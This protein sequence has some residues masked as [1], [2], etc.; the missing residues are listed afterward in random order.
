M[1]WA[2]II[3]ALISAAATLGGVWLS[4]IFKAKKHGSN[5][6]PKHI[7]RDTVIYEVISSLRE[8][9]HFSRV[10]V[11]LFHNG[12]KYYHGEPMQK[13]SVA[14]ETLFPGVEPL[15]KSMQDVPVSTMTYSLKILSE[16]G[17]FIVHDVS[18]LDNPNYRNLMLSYNETQHYAFKVEDENGW[19]GV[20]VCDYTNNEHAPLN[21]Q[22]AEYIKIQAGRLATLLKLS[23]KSYKL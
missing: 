19:V 5:I 21:D 20:L 12:S 14:F 15:A 17:R 3:V 7:Q 22:C 18:K 11:I 10:V 8:K 6:L 1:P 4:N 16:T 2:D 13:A 9:F 23:N